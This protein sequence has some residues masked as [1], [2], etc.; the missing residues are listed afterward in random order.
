MER[1]AHLFCD[2]DVLV[3]I[4]ESPRI[5]ISAKVRLIGYYNSVHFVSSILMMPGRVYSADY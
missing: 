1:L 3:S 4:S 5:A 2:N